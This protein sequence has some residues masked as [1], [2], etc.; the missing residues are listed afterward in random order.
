MRFYLVA[1][2]LNRYGDRA[3]HII[4]ERL[5]FWFTLSLVVLILGIIAATWLF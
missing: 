4:E 5:T 3:R 1:F 2:L